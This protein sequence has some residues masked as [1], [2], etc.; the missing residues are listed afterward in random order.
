MWPATGLEFGL[1]STNSK[2]GSTCGHG[3]AIHGWA[4]LTQAR[5]RRDQEGLADS[6]AEAGFPR[7]SGS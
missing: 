7:M 3:Q 2:L 5:F 4:R 1:R 6:R